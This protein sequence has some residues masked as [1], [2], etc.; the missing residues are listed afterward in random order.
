MK[1]AACVPSRIRRYL[2]AASGAVREDEVGDAD[3]P[4]Q[5]SVACRLTILVNKTE[6]RRI[7]QHR[8][9]PNSATYRA[10]NICL[11]KRIRINKLTLRRKWATTRAMWLRL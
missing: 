9:M 3:S 4:V 10:C 6:R 1:T 8:E 2:R 7:E 5:L 11:T